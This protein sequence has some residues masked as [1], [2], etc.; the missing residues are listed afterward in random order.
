M[1]GF[2]DE[3]DSVSYGLIG[4]RRQE[5]W[6][7]ALKA[8]AAFGA[9]AAVFLLASNGGARIGILNFVL[10]MSIPTWR[11]SPAESSVCS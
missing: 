3:E 8:F 4:A 10:M 9:L 1:L 5:R 7:T 2:A 6:S 11:L